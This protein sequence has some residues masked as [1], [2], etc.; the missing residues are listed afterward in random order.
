[1]FSFD[2]PVGVDPTKQCGRVVVPEMHVEELAAHD[3]WP[4]E[5][6]ADPTMTAQDLAFEFMFF[7]SLACLSPVGAAP[8][9]P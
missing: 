1:M 2:T 4:S 5:C 6:G 7:R 8:P 9:K 3:A